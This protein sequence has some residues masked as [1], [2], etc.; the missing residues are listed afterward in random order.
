MT[1][2]GDGS[3]EGDWRHSSKASIETPTLVLLKFAREREREEASVD[4]SGDGGFEG[5]RRCSRITGQRQAQ[6]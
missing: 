3:V 5:G 2:A 1:T 4:G 6:Q